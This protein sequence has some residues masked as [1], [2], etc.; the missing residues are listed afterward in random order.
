MITHDNFLIEGKNEAILPSNFIFTYIN[1][2]KKSLFTISVDTKK[3]R[4]KI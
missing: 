2:K 3:Y 4:I 1:F